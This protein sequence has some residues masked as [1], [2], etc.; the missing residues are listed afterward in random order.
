MIEHESAWAT[1]FAAIALGIPISAQIAEVLIA[2]LDTR[3]ARTTPPFA[4]SR[5]LSPARLFAKHLLKPSSLPVVTVIALTIGEVLGGSLVTEAVFGR[6]GV[7]S[8]VQRSA[9]A[10]DLPVLQAVVALAAL[11][12]VLVNLA[13]DLVYPPLD[14]RIKLVGPTGAPVGLRRRGRQRD[15]HP[16]GD[17]MNTASLPSVPH[18]AAG[19]LSALRVPPSVALALAILALVL[20]WSLAPGLFTAY[21][22]ARGSRPTSSWARAPRTGSV[23]TISAATLRPDRPRHRLLGDERALGGRH[24]GAAGG[25]IGLLSG[26][27]GGLVDT[28]LARLVDVCWRSR[29]SSSPSSSSRRSASTPS[30]PPSR[31]ASRRSRVFARVMRAEVIKTRQATS[32]R[33]RSCRA[34]RAGT[35]CGATCCRTPRA[36]CSPLAVLQVGLSILVIAGLA[37]LGYGDPPPA[38][39]WGLLIATG[40]DYLK[41][42]WLVYAPA[43]VTVAAVLSLNRISRWLRRTD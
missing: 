37:F 29:A 1:L 27:L 33:R 21:D 31:P 35:S 7:G 20:A 34:A 22:P 18:P 10:Q 42:P 38:S 9:A 28:L 36:R 14:P 17:R 12:F 3:H 5:G 25:L 6:N 23:P 11:V 16:H 13:A 15:R 41:W 24:R 30:T 19:R 39:D 4:R 8:L 32:S 26:F 43:L 2:N 40:K